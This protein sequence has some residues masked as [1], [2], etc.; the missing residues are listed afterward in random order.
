MTSIV[1]RRKSKFN[2]Y[3]DLRENPTELLE[4]AIKP[5]KEYDAF[6]RIEDITDEGT[7]EQFDFDFPETNPLDFDGYVE[8]KMAGMMRLSQEPAK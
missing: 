1:D 7:F 3:K 6:D 2:R 8:T 5:V 4:P